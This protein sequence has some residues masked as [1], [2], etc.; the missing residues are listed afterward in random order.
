MATFVRHRLASV[1]RMST[2]ILRVGL[3]CLLLWSSLP[4]IR[5]SYDFLGSVYG[6]Q[7][8]GPRMGVFVAAALPWLEFVVGVCLLTG[9][10][11]GGALLLCAG[12]TAMFTV[13]LATALYRGLAISCGCFGNSSTAVISYVTLARAVVLL[14]LSILAYGGTARMARAMP[15]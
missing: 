6:Y 5:H 7:L 8:V 13:V 1:F 9:V 14:L 10:F 15:K 4:K 2:P 12:L 3:G 11:V